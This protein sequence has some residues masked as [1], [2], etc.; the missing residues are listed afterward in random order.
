M[1]LIYF[2]A[3]RKSII[4][5]L[6]SIINIRYI[7]GSCASL[8]EVCNADCDCCGNDLNKNI[9][10]ELR[11]QIP[12]SKRCYE[13]KSLGE[14]C[15]IDSQCNSQNC[16]SNI[17]RPI[18]RP[19]PQNPT[20]FCP[21]SSDPSSIIAS[22]DG[23]LPKCACPKGPTQDAS[24]SMDN[25]LLTDYVN[26]NSQGYSGFIVQ[27]TFSA[28]LRKMEVC[29]SNANPENDPMCYRIEGKCEHEKD[30]ILLQDGSVPFGKSRQNCVTI[31]F[32][33]RLS[34]THYKVV[35]GCRRGGYEESCQGGRRLNSLRRKE[36]RKLNT[37]CAGDYPIMLSEV[38]LSGKCNEGLQ[39]PTKSPTTSFPTL[40]PTSFPTNKPT[41][42]PTTKPT[43]PSTKIPT[44][45][46][47][48]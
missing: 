16:A 35:F 47:T 6:L 10:C 28:P 30:F 13:S 34:Y 42:F 23:S 37:Y 25:N 27:P 33:G 36:V 21:L 2:N 24:Y 45:P 4:A 14:P 18:R 26:Y 40:K 9:R 8:F 44:K 5:L 41:L 43:R 19:P 29:T 48:R 11:N 1:N 3:S 20:P 38:K 31:L 39:K 15:T 22:V 12:I 7:H 17:C 32:D 46:L